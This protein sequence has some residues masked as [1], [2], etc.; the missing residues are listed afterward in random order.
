MAAA[1][2]D[3]VRHA[4]RCPRSG[5]RQRDR[6]V[7]RRES[8]KPDGRS[9][10][11]DAAVGR[12]VDDQ[13]PVRR[14]WAKLFVAEPPTQLLCVRRFRAGDGGSAV[15]H[16]ARCRRD[17]GYTRRPVGSPCDR[18]RYGQRRQR[19]DN[20]EPESGE[21][22]HERRL[23]G[24]GAW[25]YPGPPA[26]CS[27]LHASRPRAL[28]P[29]GRAS[30]TRPDRGSAIARDTTTPASRTLASSSPDIAAHAPRPAASR[31]PG[32]STRRRPDPRTSGEILHRPAS[33]D[34]GRRGRSYRH[35]KTQR[36]PATAL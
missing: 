33:G 27:A 1:R 11:R 31:A 7:R 30:A 9:Q 12:T 32:P 18:G 21:E 14:G 20:G 2:G 13:R 6:E 17:A 10:R 34:P 22:E 3:G 4:V 16:L 19:L 15:R 25:A 28:S 8:G 5:A 23:A 35:S 29:L 36:I 24:P 26:S